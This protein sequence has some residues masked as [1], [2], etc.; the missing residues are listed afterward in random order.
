[1]E[2][3]PFDGSCVLIIGEYKDDT[4]YWWSPFDD[5]G[6][7]VCEVVDSK[8]G[9]AEAARVGPNLIVLV[10]GWTE[11]DYLELTRQLRE[12]TWVPLII[13]SRNWFSDKTISAL[14]EAGANCLAS[15]RYFPSELLSGVNS[16]AEFIRESTD[17]YIRKFGRLRIHLEMRQ[18]WLGSRRLRLSDTEFALLRLF[19][20]N[21]GKVLTH[22][23]IL[24]EVWGP[25]YEDK[26]HFLRV[27]ISKLRK[28]IERNPAKPKLLVTEEGVGYRFS[29]DQTA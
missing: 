16:L 28:R 2:S 9:L 26:S 13:L 6:F 17:E 14:A 18:V 25:G 12:I 4:R 21:P 20:N 8:Q 22:N 10:E 3:M 29:T 23:Q 5:L 7:R 11:F 1:M 27:Y 19:V 24:H 15:T